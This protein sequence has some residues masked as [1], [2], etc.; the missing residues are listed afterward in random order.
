M[1]TSHAS[2][3]ACGGVKKETKVFDKDDVEKM[4]AL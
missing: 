2:V 4:R 3:Q 1:T